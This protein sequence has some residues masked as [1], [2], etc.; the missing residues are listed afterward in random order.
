MFALH[1]IQIEER[2]WN[3]LC[4]LYIVFFSGFLD[5]GATAFE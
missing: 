5:L 3:S 1:F 4:F 2:L